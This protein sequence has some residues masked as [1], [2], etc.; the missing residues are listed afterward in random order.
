MRLEY[1]NLITCNRTVVVSD[2]IEP[3]KDLKESRLGFEASAPKAK[4]KSETSNS[5]SDNADS[6]IG[7]LQIH[8]R[9]AIKIESGRDWDRIGEFSES[10]R[11]YVSE[12]FGGD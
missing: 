10:P 6:R 2:G 11:K 4:S 1:W 12:R 3:I 5:R 7:T 8:F 9:F